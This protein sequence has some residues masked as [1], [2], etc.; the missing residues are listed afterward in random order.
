M[1]LKT[2][3]ISC[4]SVCS[5]LAGVSVA[6]AGAFGLREQSAVGQGNAFA[7]AAAGAAGLGSMF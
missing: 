2:I 5:L 6:H 4:V 3:A 1:K 7:G